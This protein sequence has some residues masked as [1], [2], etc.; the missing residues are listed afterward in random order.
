MVGVELRPVDED[1]E[2]VARLTTTATAAAAQADMMAA[3]TIHFLLLRGSTL[4]VVGVISAER[5]AD[6]PAG[7]ACRDGVDIGAASA[8]A[9]GV[10]RLSLVYRKAT[11][12]P[13]AC[14]TACNPSPRSR[15]S[16]LTA[17]IR[18]GN[19]PLV[20]FNWM[21]WMVARPAVSV[22]AKS[23]RKPFEK[24]PPGPSGGS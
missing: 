3:N 20:R 17:V 12:R 24:R 2:L 10:G 1:F 14:I 5:S 6:G 16:C 21:D 9:T 4:A 11:V 22:M 15:V 8:G 13:R 19:C 18:M 23:V 7:T